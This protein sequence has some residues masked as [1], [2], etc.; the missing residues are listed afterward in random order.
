MPPRRRF[1]VVRFSLVDIVIVIV[2]DSR[3][4]ADHPD[5]DHPDD[6]DDE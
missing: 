6:R 4:N 5:P 3:L 2:D 1:S